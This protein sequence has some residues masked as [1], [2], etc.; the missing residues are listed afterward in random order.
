[1]S[2]EDTIELAIGQVWKSYAGMVPERLHKEV[3]IIEISNEEIRYKYLE[4][5]ITSVRYVE[6]FDD[7]FEFVRDHV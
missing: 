7:Y 1:M 5:G 6:S 2:D 3:V 4:D